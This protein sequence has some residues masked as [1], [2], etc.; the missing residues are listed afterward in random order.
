MHHFFSRVSIKSILLREERK[1]FEYWNF[2][3][4]HRKIKVDSIPSF[5]E[6]CVHQKIYL[7]LG[8]LFEYYDGATYHLN[9]F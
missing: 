5:I 7:A 2:F 1:D 3:F 8:Q 6:F 9:F 4:L